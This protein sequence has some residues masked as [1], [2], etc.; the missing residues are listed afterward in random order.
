MKIRV[1]L[2]EG[3]LMPERAH[4]AD[5]GAD[6]RTPR[7]VRVPARGQ[8]F[9]D[10]G[11]HMEIPEGYVGILKSKSGPNKNKGITVTGTIDAGYTG[12]IGVVLQNH[13]GMDVEFGKGAK[14][15]Q[16]V[17][18]PIVP[19][20]FVRVGSMEETERGSGGFGSTGI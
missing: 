4:A 9:V 13:S 2:D 14:I 7:A 15:T 18:L 20:D 12:S 5:A 8:A 16:I 3:A 19:A 17:I 11:V 6:L 1:V 10:T